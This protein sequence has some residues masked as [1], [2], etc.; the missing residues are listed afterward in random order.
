MRVDFLLNRRGKDGDAGY[1]DQ[2]GTSPRFRGPSRP[3]DAVRFRGDHNRPS[4]PRLHPKA[5]A[6]LDRST[7]V[8][9]AHSQ[10]ARAFKFPF[11]PTD[12][13]KIRYIY[14]KVGGAYDA[15]R[16]AALALNRSQTSLRI[17]RR[18]LSVFHERCPQCAA[19]RTEYKRLKEQ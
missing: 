18:E 19:R 12:D 15:D 1:Y 8:C 17:R 7:Q 3:L 4:A 11:T 2:S 16:V 6:S 5:Q 10:S 14:R 13:A 9:W